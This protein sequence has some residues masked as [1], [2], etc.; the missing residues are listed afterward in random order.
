MYTSPIFPAIFFSSALLAEAQ[1]R[2]P[3]P[4]QHVLD[5]PPDPVGQPEAR[6]I[7]VR[8]VQL[9]VLREPGPLDQAR[10]IR[11][12]PA[13]HGHRR[14]VIEAVH[15]DAVPRASAEAERA[16]QGVQAATSCPCQRRLEEPVSRLGIVLAIEEIEMCAAHLLV[17]VVPV[18]FLHGEAPDHAGTPTGKEELG[19]RVLEEGVPTGQDPA[20]VSA[21]PRHPLGHVAKEAVRQLDE[22]LL[23]A[24]PGDGPDG[25]GHDRSSPAGLYH[26]PGRLPGPRGSD[27]RHRRAYSRGVQPI[28]CRNWREK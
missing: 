1:H 11:R 24:L 20:H 12:V 14:G 4:G 23:V 16:H 9:E 15:E 7:E 8:G 5:H 19:L 28:S 21:E 25:N 3:L 10:I 17:L 2:E 22:L 26:A 6:G 13:H 27:R 18:V